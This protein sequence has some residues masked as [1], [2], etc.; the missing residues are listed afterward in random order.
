[1]KS[2]LFIILTGFSFFLNF[3]CQAPKSNE[4]DIND[5]MVLIVENGDY[6]Q[7]KMRVFI[8]SIKKTPQLAAWI[9][10]N[11][12]NYLSTITVTNKGGK[13]SWR[14]APKEGRPEALPVWNN[15]VLNS[16]SESIDAVSSASSKETLEAHITDNVLSQGNEYNLYLEINHSFDYNDFWTKDNSGVN[17][18]PS[19]IYHAKFIA[20]KPGKVN[21]VPVGHG[22][23]DGSNGK[24][25]QALDNLTTSLKIIKSAVLTIS[26]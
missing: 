5:S 20:G 12:E 14:S 23:V 25:T 18:Q 10:D 22:S 13:K 15:K 6:W 3:S 4:T 19:V 26:P 11:N 24:I 21:L 7:G 8:F 1:M 16:S 2:Y 17:G 9:D